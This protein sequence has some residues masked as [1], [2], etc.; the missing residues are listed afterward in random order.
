MTTL[1]AD[2]VT[3]YPVAGDPDA[4]ELLTGGQDAPPPRVATR[5]ELGA[6]HRAG[7]A[8]R[9]APRTGRARRGRTLRRDRTRGEEHPGDTDGA[10]GETCDRPHRG[11]PGRW[12]PSSGG[13]AGRMEL[14][15]RGWIEKV[16]AAGR[17]N[18]V[19]HLTLRLVALGVDVEEALLRGRLTQGAQRRLDVP[20]GFV[21]RTNNPVPADPAAI[22]GRGA[23]TGDR[24]PQRRPGNGRQPG[25]ARPRPGGEAPGVRRPGRAPLLDRRPPHAPPGLA[26]PRP[27]PGAYA[28]RWEGPLAEAPRPGRVHARLTARL[29]APLTAGPPRPPSG[30]GRARRHSPDGRPPTGAG[31]AAAHAVT[32]PGAPVHRGSPTVPQEGSRGPVTETPARGVGTR[33]RG[34]GYYAEQRTRAWPQNSP[35]SR[36]TT[37]P[38]GCGASS[39]MSPGRGGPSWSSARAGS[40]AWSPSAGHPSSGPADP[41]GVW[42][43]YDA[44]RVKEAFRQGAGLLREHRPRGAP[45]RPPRAAGARL[46]RS[47]RPTDRCPT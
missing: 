38:A 12:E 15:E 2:A 47:P 34:V 27:A 11:G 1:V 37:S 7:A 20:D 26:R 9:P 5:Q 33:E 46:R 43:H 23:R 28:D 19:A 35:P 3:D 4:Q 22:S 42:E 32:V 41:A 8:L 13:T 39:T 36:S 17:A 24:D 6:A 18:L 30:A 25:G 29:P 10:D 40:T 21:V 31:E 16:T 14:T 45:P 44:E